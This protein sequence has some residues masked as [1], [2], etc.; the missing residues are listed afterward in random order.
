MT[1]GKKIAVGVGGGIGI[2]ALGY[3][4]LDKIQERMKK[5]HKDKFP[6]KAPEEK[7]E[8]TPQAEV[9]ETI[10]VV[11]TP[12]L[13]YLDNNLEDVPPEEPEHSEE[14]IR[15]IT[16]EDYL[17][18]GSRKKVQWRYYMEEGVLTTVE[19]LPIIDPRS[20]LGNLLDT[21][22]SYM[23]PDEVTIY[24]R[25]DKNGT[26]YEIKTIAPIEMFKG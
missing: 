20:E 1:L 17:D 2:A 21:V 19:D 10:A 24:I 26:D 16:A 25:N 12:D 7:E 15:L 3:L 23:P 18:D 11:E 22:T 13:S 4:L 9:P 5:R 14:P 8:K 6:E